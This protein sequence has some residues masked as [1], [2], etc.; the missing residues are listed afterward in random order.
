MIPRRKPYEDSPPCR[1]NIITVATPGITAQRC[2]ISRYTGVDGVDVLE[3]ACSWQPHVD[4]M[5]IEDHAAD[6]LLAFQ[7]G[8]GNYVLTAEEEPPLLYH[9]SCRVAPRLLHNVMASPEIDEVVY[10]KCSFNPL[11]W[12]LMLKELVTSLAFSV[13]PRRCAYSQVRMTNVGGNRDQAVCRREIRKAVRIIK[14]A[15]VKSQRENDLAAHS[16][17]GRLLPLKLVLFGCSRGA[18]TTFYT[19][20]KLP[21]ELAQYVSL[22][23][24]EAPFDTLHNVINSSCWFPR[25]TLWFVR[26]FC[27][28]EGD[29]P[30]S[31]DPDRVQLRCPIAFVMSVKDTR[32]PNKLTRRLIDTV[33]RECPQIPAVEVLELKHSR[34]PL[35]AVGNR[36]DQ[37]AYVAFM[38]RLYA[39][40]CS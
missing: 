20:M 6:E 34:H 14:K 40:Y 21:L 7:M 30:Y 16:S 12:L 5:T 37:D 17:P 31:F 33:R 3:N 24:V 36:E 9:A 28:Y 23:V 32:V 13:Y 4:S 22:V 11:H 1:Q 15:A 38:E 10:N 19:A 26:N 25:L 18:T 39:T 8:H 2:Q 35:M 27:D 29:E